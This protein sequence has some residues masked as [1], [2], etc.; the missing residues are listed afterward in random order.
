[1]SPSD[2]SAMSFIKAAPYTTRTLGW[3]LGLFFG[4][5]TSAQ[6]TPQLRCEVTYAGKTHVLTAQPVSDPYSV[7]AVDIGGRF[8][9]KMVMVGRAT[10]IDHILVYAYLDQEPRPVIVQESK[11]LPPFRVSAQPY[12]LTGEQHVYAGPIER[13]L[14]YR[15][16]LGG[17][18]S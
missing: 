9:F 1:M 15:C 11:Y 12:L 13:E 7:A 4:L 18:Q 14:I 5:W 10:K 6:A 8:L 3:V 17:V 2:F 16:W